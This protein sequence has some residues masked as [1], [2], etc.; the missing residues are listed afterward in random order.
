MAI[1]IRPAKTTTGY[2]DERR[3]YFN[4]ATPSVPATGRPGVPTTVFIGANRTPL[5]YR[6][7]R[8]YFQQQPKGKRTTCTHSRI[9]AKYG[10][11]HA[12]AGL[13]EYMSLF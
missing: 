11:I 10:V 9:K 1:G 5:P 13:V 7:P 12:A 3:K 8:A 4:P 2:P 6:F